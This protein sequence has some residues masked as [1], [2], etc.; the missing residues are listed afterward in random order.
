MIWNDQLGILGMGDKDDV[1][2]QTQNYLELEEE[3]SIL[4]NKDF[5]NAIAE[6]YDVF[7]WMSSSALVDLYELAELTKL[8]PY[9]E[10]D[11]RANYLHS[12]LHFEDDEIR[13]ETQGD[14]DLV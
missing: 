5:R 8:T 10:E 7:N 14:G 1:R 2:T 4:N 9:T 12:Y 3:Q 6:D 13:A 11:L